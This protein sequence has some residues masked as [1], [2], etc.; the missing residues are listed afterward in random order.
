MPLSFMRTRIALHLALLTLAV[1]PISCSLHNNIEQSR[2][3]EFNS[4]INSIEPWPAQTRVYPHK[5]WE[6]LMSAA[7]TIQKW[8]PSSLEKALKVNQ[9]SYTGDPQAEIENDGKLYLLMRAVFD[10]PENA[11]PQDTML[12]GWVTYR[13]Q[14]N[15]DGTVNA[16]WPIR[17]NRGEPELVSGYRGRQGI[18]GRY[19]ADEEY[20]Y[21]LHKYHFRVYD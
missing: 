21:F 13:T 7:K 11:P 8:S 15:S 18:N 3:A 5:G 6:S 16:A 10:L 4:L 14:Y 20:R 12:W 9:S 19:K 2:S 1:M 17:W